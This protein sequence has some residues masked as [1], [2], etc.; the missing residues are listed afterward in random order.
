MRK[1][2][3][4]KNPED[5]FKWYKAYIRSKDYIRMYKYRYTIKQKHDEYD[6]F[7]EASTIV[8]EYRIF[9]CSLNASDKEYITRCFNV[10][11]LIYPELDCHPDVIDNWMTIVID[12]KKHVFYEIDI[13]LLGRVLKERRN[14]CGFYR[15]EAARLLGISDNTL[16]SYEDGKREIGITLLYKLMQLYEVGDISDFLF[17]CTKTKNE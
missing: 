7:K 13:K 4:F 15:S 14:L 10:G 16:R 11:Y 9:M 3:F 12:S 8:Q 2:Y 1:H 5:F 17:E 6:I